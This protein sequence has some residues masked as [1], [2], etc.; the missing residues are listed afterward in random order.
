MDEFDGFAPG[1]EPAD[2]FDGGDFGD[3]TGPSSPFDD[4]DDGEEL[5]GFDDFD[6]GADPA[7]LD[8][9]L[10]DD[11]AVEDDFGGDDSVPEEPGESGGDETAY[12]AT[13]EDMLVADAD[14]PPQ[15][16][17]ELDLDVPEPVDGYPWVDLDTL[18]ESETEPWAVNTAAGGDFAAGDLDDD[19]AAG[20]LARFWQR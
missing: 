8:A 17:P 1:D 10:E 20:A 16:P 12:A 3:D 18:G 11:F 15:F 14:N 7:G 4:F 13:Y 2:G 19:P 5:G 6:D 9:G